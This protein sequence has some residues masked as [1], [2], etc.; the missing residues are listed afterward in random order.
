MTS[1]LTPDE[2]IGLYVS[3]KRRAHYEHGVVLPPRPGTKAVRLRLAL[4]DG[5]TV[6]IDDPAALDLTPHHSLTRETKTNKILATAKR[7]S[8][9]PTYRYGDLP[10]KHLAT[11]TM[12]RREHRRKPAPGQ[13]PIAYYDAREMW[14]PLYAVVDAAELPPLPTARAEAFTGARTCTVCL[15][16][17]E[18]PLPKSP[19]GDRYCEPCHQEAAEQRWLEQA[20]AAQHQAAT[21]AREVLADPTAVLV[22]RD[23]DWQIPAYRIETF[24][25]TQLLHAKIRSFEDVETI[26]LGNDTPAERQKLRDRY[27]GTVSAR[28]I[29]P[30]L[31]ALH[32]R[33]LITWAGLHD[34]DFYA[35]DSE[36]QR[37]LTPMLTSALDDQI[38]P[39]FALW[40]PV[41]PWRGSGFWYRQPELSSSY[42][43]H[44]GHIEHL[45]RVAPNLASA[46]ATIRGR[47]T[48]M[49]TETAPEPRIAK[50]ITQ[51]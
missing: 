14:A 47:L 12:L 6:R 8:G 4:D 34:Q 11:K 51:P 43:G 2:L 29:L 49:A 20:R 30:Q 48:A 50:D 38:S 41:A 45:L 9:R 19:E 15:T 35:W 37:R 36:N 44:D 5:R 46:L 33:R 42:T 18:R 3:V 16:V 31:E 13:L 7:V 40:S 21:W 10:A 39:H 24:D 1:T 28:E 23:R 26:R 27:A 25:G 32:G 22:H 17:F